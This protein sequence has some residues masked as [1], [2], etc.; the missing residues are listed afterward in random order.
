MS[1]AASFIGTDGHARSAGEPSRIQRAAEARAAQPGSRYCDLP[2]NPH[3]CPKTR[4]KSGVLGQS[5]FQGREE[6]GVSR[7]PRASSRSG[8]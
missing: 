7:R 1:L 3:A 2:K 6:T 5:P 4:Y 8:A